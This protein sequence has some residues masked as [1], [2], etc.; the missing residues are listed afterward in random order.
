VKD[1]TVAMVA[2]VRGEDEFIDEWIIYHYLLGATEFV[3]YDDDPR[4]NLKRLLG[5]HGDLVRV[6]DWES[7]YGL[8]PGRNRQTRA[9]QHSL[10]E[11]SCDWVAFLDIDEFIVL[12]NRDRLPT[13]LSGFKDADSV[14]LTWH[15]F[16]HSGFYDPP[17]LVTQ[18]LLRRQAAPSRMMKSI[19][20][21]D[22]VVTVKSAHLCSMKYVGR[23]HDANHRVYTDE[24]YP[25]KTDV[26][27]VNHYFCRCF[28]QWMNRVRRGEVAYSR[29]EYPRSEAW[30]YEEAECLRKFVKISAF[31][32]EL[33]DDY[34]LK[35]G[36][37]IR[38][39]LA[40]LQI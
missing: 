37:Q 40:A 6:I 35:Y 15:Y 24:F 20:R 14:I 8:L 2:I 31:H 22:Q 16:G 39:R 12:R 10:S 4:Q 28:T 23:A 38:A 11:T 30:R 33:V 21:R 9:Y 25:G 26:A 34:L 7:G 18:C 3:L 1:E 17:A 27:H 36:D 29:N 5:K 13:F 19:V 32:N